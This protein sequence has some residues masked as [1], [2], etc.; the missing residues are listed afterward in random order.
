MLQSLRPDRRYII[1]ILGGVVVGL[2]AVAVA[3]TPVLAQGKGGN[4]CVLA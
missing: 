4:S 1:K 2:M 3:W